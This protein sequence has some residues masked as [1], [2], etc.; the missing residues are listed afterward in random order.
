MPTKL[1]TDACALR[2]YLARVSVA[3]EEVFAAELALARPKLKLKMDASLLEMVEISVSMEREKRK[4]TMM[5]LIGLPDKEAVPLMTQAI[6]EVQ[7]ISQIREA[8]SRDAAAP[9][10]SQQ[11]LRRLLFDD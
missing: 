9:T 6:T 3:M 2:R 10:P 4:T 11:E 5:R 8:L 7:H 1:P